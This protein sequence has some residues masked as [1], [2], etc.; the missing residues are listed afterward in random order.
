MSDTFKKWLQWDE[1]VIQANLKV[2]WPSHW[3]TSFKRHQKIEEKMKTSESVV[4]GTIQKLRCTC[5]WCASRA[6]DITRGG[7]KKKR[8]E[9]NKPF[10]SFRVENGFLCSRKVD[11]IPRLAW[12]WK[13][14]IL[15]C[16]QYGFESGGNGRCWTLYCSTSVEEC[17]GR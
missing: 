15:R 10:S 9:Q 8:F 11:P 3:I 7:K 2:T 4:A 16:H 13:R 14:K 5:T 6:F 12:H 17:P 1:E